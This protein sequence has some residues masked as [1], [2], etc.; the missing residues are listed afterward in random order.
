M[1]RGSAVHQVLEDQVH[2]TVHVELETKEDAWGLRIWN[3]IQGL[4]TL[5]DEGLTRELEIW[6]TVD[7]LVVN[8]VIDELS[9]ICPDTEMEESLQKPTPQDELP[10]DQASI[11]DFF[12]TAGGTSLAEATRSKRRTRTK[13]V[14]LCDVKT[15]GVRNLPS[16]AAFRPTKIQ[17]MLYHRLLSALATNNVDFSILTARYSLDPSKTFSDSFLAQIGGLNESKEKSFHDAQSEP[18]LSQDSKPNWSQDS[19]ATLLAH[20]N[21]SAIWSLMITEFQVTLPDGAASLGN[22]LKAEYRSRDDG[23]IVGSKTFAM[24]ELDLSTYINHEMKWW[25]GERQAEGVAVEEAFKCRSCEFADGCEWRIKKVEEAK[26][27]VRMMRKR[28]AAI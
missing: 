23:E 18:D 8:G 25:K 22:V 26:E 21:L 7:G 2:T 3:V 5:R 19:L 17:L 20:N 14:Y 15:R 4:R 1:K 9:Y 16:G 27:K 11:S 10:P 12:K 24:D 28:T 6:G 13:K